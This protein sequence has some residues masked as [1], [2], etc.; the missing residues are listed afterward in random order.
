M[1]R[2]VALALVVALSG[3]AT[4]GGDVMAQRRADRE[5]KDAGGMVALAGAGLTVGAALATP[6]VLPRGKVGVQSPQDHSA[7]AGVAWALAGAA[8]LGVAAAG[9]GL[10]VAADDPDQ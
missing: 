3:C 8:A 6:F 9:A 4:T 7:A 10:T 1:F 5:R 2:A